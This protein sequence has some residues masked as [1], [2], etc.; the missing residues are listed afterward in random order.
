MKVA[1]CL[2]RRGGSSPGHEDS[3]LTLARSRPSWEIIRL[4]GCPCVDLARAL[5]AEDAL[6]IGADVILSIDSDTSFSVESCDRVVEQAFETAGVVGAAYARKTEGERI[7]LRWDGREL[8]FYEGGSLERVEGVGLG[9]TAAHRMTFER[10]DLRP[11]RFDDGKRKRDVRPFYTNDVRWE[12]AGGEDDAFMRRARE[13]GSPIFCDTRI[14]VGHE[15]KKTYYLEDGAQA[16]L[17]KTLRIKG[18]P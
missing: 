4:D 13:S 7:A 3:L 17:A 14:R 11:Q 8:T 2:P 9:F 10:M 1:I 18:A 15:G 6:A 12:T 16:R 5:L